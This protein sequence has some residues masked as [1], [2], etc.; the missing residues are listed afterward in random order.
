MLHNINNTTVHMISNVYP[1]KS[2]VLI[3]NAI[4]CSS[5]VYTNTEMFLTLSLFLLRHQI[6]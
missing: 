2:M 6:C 5:Q 4:K 1:R 3:R